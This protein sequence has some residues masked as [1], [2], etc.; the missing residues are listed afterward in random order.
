VLAQGQDL[1]SSCLQVRETPPTW[2]EIHQSRRVVEVET[3]HLIPNSTPRHH[4]R[5]RPRPKLE[6]EQHCYLRKLLLLLPCSLHLQLQ[7]QQ[8]QRLPHP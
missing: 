2:M 6:P 4:R 7:R 1:N 3:R 8:P 5:I